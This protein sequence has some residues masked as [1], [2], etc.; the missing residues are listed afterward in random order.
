MRQL[1]WFSNSCTTPSMVIYHSNSDWADTEHI[2][3]SLSVSC[4]F[5]SFYFVRP[6]LLL[7]YAFQGQAESDSQRCQHSA[8]IGWLDPKCLDHT[9]YK[10]H[11]E[12]S[13]KVVSQIWERLGKVQEDIFTDAKSINCHLRL[14]PTA[15]WDKKHWHMTGLTVSYLS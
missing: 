10:S 3:V 7:M 1:S 9:K 11:G 14:K 13:N 12:I 2:C 5:P 4:K 6:F 15:L 8:I